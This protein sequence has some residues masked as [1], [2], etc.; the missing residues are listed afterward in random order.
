[1][2]K[3][4]SAH[5]NTIVPFNIY[6]WHSSN[7]IVDIGLEGGETVDVET[8]NLEEFV[9]ENN[10][11]PPTIIKCDIEG[12]EDEFINSL[13]DKFFETINQINLEFH[14]LPYEKFGKLLT[15]FLKLGYTISLKE[16]M[17]EKRMMGTINLL[18][19]NIRINE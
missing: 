18:K 14:Y 6:P 16:E 3:A 12:L 8:I 11:L 13:S 7:S 5:H 4:I 19:T 15:R 10:L 9:K 1:M 17:N 2:D